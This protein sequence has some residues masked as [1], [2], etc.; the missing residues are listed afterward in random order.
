MHYNLY[1]DYGDKILTPVP[2]LTE[3]GEQILDRNGTPMYVRGGW[4]IKNPTSVSALNSFSS[5][6]STHHM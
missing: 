4:G 6:V 5:Q 2:F 3:G 1:D